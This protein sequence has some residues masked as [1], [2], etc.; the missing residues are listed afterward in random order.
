MAFPTF[1][2]IE[3]AAYHRWE[4]RG[5]SHGEHHGDWF[6][7][8]QDLLFSMNYEVVAHY[9]LSG[10]ARQVVGD[11]KRPVCRFCER[12]KPSANFS[13]NALALPE[14][15]GNTSLF[16]AETCEECR[17]LF[18][19]EVDPGLVEFLRSSR[20]NRWG[21]RHP[22]SVAA[23][24]ALAK[25]ALTLMPRRELP[26]FESAIEWVGNPDHDFDVNLFE[27]HDGFLHV[28]SVTFSHPW[29]ALARKVEDDAPMPYM[30]LFLGT[31]DVVVQ[32]P[33]PLCMSDEDL[34][35]ETLIIPKLCAPTALELPGEPV[36]WV[37]V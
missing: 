8:E 22:L 18:E 25:T 26:T 34:D 10:L 32:I 3:R 30:L 12:A 21:S 15:I 20:S 27:A 29:V 14:A 4:R 1:D 28:S 13:D 33:V 19:E 23:L 36:A 11:R 16:S 5:Y 2:Q 6:A 9:G 24:K 37:S 31:S 35:G 17:S 7:S